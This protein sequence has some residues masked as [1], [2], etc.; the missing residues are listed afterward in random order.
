MSIRNRLSLSRAMPRH[1][2]SM[3]RFAS[4]LRLAGIGLIAALAPFARADVGVTTLPATADDD[5][6]TVF[7]RSTQPATEFPVGSWAGAY[8]RD[9]VPEPGNGR[10]VVISHGSGGSPWVH[11]GLARALVAAGYVV[12]VPRHHADNAGDPSQPGP[13]SWTR[14]PVEVSHAID[15][16]AQD[17]RFA[18]LLQLDA[19]GVY[20]M[21]AGGHTALELAGGQWSPTGFRDHCRVHMAEDFPACVGLATGQD[22]NLLDPLKRWVARQVIDWRFRDAQP[23]HHTDPRIAAVVAAVPFAAD[24]DMATLVQPAVP[25]ALATANGDRWLAPRFHGDRVLRACARCE[26][27]VGLPNGGHGAYL[28][29]LPPGVGGRLGGLINDPPGFERTVEPAIEAKVVDFF[30]RRLAPATGGALSIG[31]STSP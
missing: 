10:L 2:S 31:S 30:N 20:G 18:P 3:H 14:R 21:S 8:A 24:F 16:M 15:R 1:Q 17:P 12:A 6:V 19:V 4:W 7:Y 28:D 27:L 9:A 23:R 25:L 5:P 22:G 29:P 26:H 13:D 11:G